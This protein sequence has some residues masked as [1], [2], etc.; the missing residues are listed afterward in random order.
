MHRRFYNLP[1]LAPTDYYLKYDLQ[2]DFLDSSGNG[3]NGIVA[4]AL[5]TLTT[6]DG[7]ECTYFDG[8]KSFKTQAPITLSN[9]FSISFEIWTTQTAAAVVS[10]LS[11]NFNSNPGF[12]IITNS[13]NKRLSVII[14]NGAVNTYNG[15]SVNEVINGVWKKVVIIIDVSKPIGEK[16]IAVVDG[17]PYTIL[18]SNQFDTTTFNVTD[19]LFFGRRAGTSLGFIGYLRNYRIFQRALKI[20]EAIAITK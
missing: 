20:N 18:I 3:N 11:V 19:T 5:P 8:S 14:S 6:K 13:I 1:L 12:V 9:Q 16:L 2:S 7:K 10:E 17:V 4:G 15:I